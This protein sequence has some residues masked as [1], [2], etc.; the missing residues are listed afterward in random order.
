MN[1]IN[2]WTQFL[3]VQERISIPNSHLIA[4]LVHTHILFSFVPSLA[5]CK[6]IIVQLKGVCFLFFLFLRFVA[7]RYRN[8]LDL[9]LQWIVYWY[10]N[11]TWNILNPWEFKAFSWQITE[12]DHS[13]FSVVANAKISDLRYSALWKWYVL[14]HPM[15]ISSLYAIVILAHHVLFLLMLSF[16]Q[17]F[18]SCH[19][20]SHR[21]QVEFLKI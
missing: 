11:Q 8:D 14:L 3:P 15:V 19:S 13:L 2:F 16:L 5:H 7:F 10:V 17:L 4:S 9:K 6:P 20:M 21:S 18:Y 12:I 1:T